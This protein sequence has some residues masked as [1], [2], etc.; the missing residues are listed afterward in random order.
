[1]FLFWGRSK[2]SGGEQSPSEGT[3]V[4]EKEGRE[5]AQEPG[6]GQRYV[7]TNCPLWIQRG[8][9]TMFKAIGS[10]SA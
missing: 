5:G 7:I 6:A 3:E 9:P 8:V 1:M 4:E 10:L 2:D